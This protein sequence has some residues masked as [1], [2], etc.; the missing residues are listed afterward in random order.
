[1]LDHICS[2]SLDGVGVTDA[3]AGTEGDKETDDET[4]DESEDDAEMLAGSFMAD[5]STP[6]T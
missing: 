4:E 5:A 6:T 3:D 1:M 2:G